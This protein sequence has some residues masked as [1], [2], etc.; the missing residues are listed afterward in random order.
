M[1]IR[2]A[3]FDVDGIVLTGRT[4]Y[5]SERFAEEQGIPVKDVTDFFMG[6]FKQC[7]FGKADLK[8]LVAPYLPKWKWDKGV[9]AFLEH[10]FK[11]EST[12]DPRVLDVVAALRGAGVK[13]YIATRNEKYRTQ[14]LLHEVGLKDHFDGSFATYEIGHDK[15][16]PD[17]FEYILGALQMAPAELLYFD[18]RQANIDTAKM[19]GLEAYFYDSFATLKEKTDSALAALAAS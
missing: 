14:Y 19:I 5:F 12:K 9:D 17:F 4:R 2:A 15:D 11:S 7:S 8:E 6:D 3:L 1:L 16:H 13:C 10:W 18:D